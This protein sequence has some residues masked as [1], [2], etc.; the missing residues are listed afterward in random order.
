MWLY[1]FTLW[2]QHYGEM[3]GFNSMLPYETLFLL[4]QYTVKLSFL[5]FHY[6]FCI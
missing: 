2:L 4:T 5:F 6:G 3:F 1:A